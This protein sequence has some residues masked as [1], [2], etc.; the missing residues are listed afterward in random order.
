[1]N[2]ISIAAMGQSLTNEEL[3]Q[4]ISEVDEEMSGTIG[5][6]IWNQSK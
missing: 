5:E 1:M 3:F 2:D 6:L 4:L